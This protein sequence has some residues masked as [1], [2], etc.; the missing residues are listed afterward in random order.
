MPTD[1]SQSQPADASREDL[2]WWTTAF[3]QPPRAAP[4]PPSLSLD[5]TAVAAR[6]TPIRSLDDLP[7]TPGSYESGLRNRLSDMQNASLAAAARMRVPGTRPGS[8]WSTE[9]MEVA[10]VHNVLR[11]SRPQGQSM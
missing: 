10:Q 5:A 8:R 11:K 4:I 3:E 9:S 7:A 1:R 6:P 2:E